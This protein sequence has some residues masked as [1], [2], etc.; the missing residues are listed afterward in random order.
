M[1]DI[2]LVAAFWFLASVVTAIIATTVITNG[3]MILI[4]Y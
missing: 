4:D 1:F 2:Y 3:I